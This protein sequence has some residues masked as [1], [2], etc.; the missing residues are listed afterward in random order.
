M[1]VL[2]LILSLTDKKPHRRRIAAGAFVIFIAAE[3]IRFQPNEYD[4]NK[5]FYVWW[6]LCSV[7]AAEYAVEIFERMRGLRS[8]YVLAVIMAVACFTTG[9]LSIARECVSDYQMFSRADVQTAE[10]VE[11]NTP[12]HSTFICWT[13]HINP[14]SALAGRNIVCGPALWLSFHGYD[15]HDREADIRA[16]YADP[17]ANDEVLRRYAVDYILI[18]EYE[19]SSLTINEDAIASRYPCIFESDNGNMRIYQVVTD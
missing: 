6:L 9:T 4:N 11:E 18:G 10:F 7:L 2:L 19:T 3:F 1:P 17:E 14:V 12:E 15:L 13:Q 8:R 16:F 5:L